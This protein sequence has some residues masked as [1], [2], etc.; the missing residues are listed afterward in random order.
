MRVKALLV[1]KRLTLFL[2]VSLLLI[3][4][5]TGSLFLSCAE[6]ASTQMPDSYIHSEGNISDYLWSPDGTKI[7]FVKCPDGQTWDCELW[8]ADKRPGSA[9]LENPQLIYTGIEWAHLEDWQGEWIL[10]MRRHEEEAPSG[11]PCEVA[12]RTRARPSKT[13]VSQTA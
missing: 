5:H 10:F 11:S 13:P 8:V 12:G 1:T 7:A 6:T 2:T 9:Q 4:P 3:L